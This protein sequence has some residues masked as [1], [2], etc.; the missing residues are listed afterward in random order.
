MSENQPTAPGGADRPA[1]DTTVPAPDAAPDAPGAEAAGPGGTATATGWQPP[2]PPGKASPTVQAP[3]P[4]AGAW[5]PP[6]APGQRPTAPPPGPATP[7]PPGAVPPG[8]PSSPPPSAPPAPAP[9]QPPAWTPP[10]AAAPAAPPAPAAG[11]PPGG[12]SPP[13]PP[14]QAAPAAQAGAPPPAS[15]PPAAGG[16]SPPAPPGQAAA[17]AAPAAAPPAAAPPAPGGWAPPSAPG[18]AAAS[19]APAAPPA[20]GGWAPPSPPGQA[21]GGTAAPPAG[22]GWAPPSAPGQAAAAAAPPTAPPAYEAPPVEPAAEA[23]IAPISKAGV[24]VA[25]TPKAT[26]ERT[27]LYV[28]TGCGIGETV[29]AEQLAAIGDAALKH[30]GSVHGP[31]CIPEGVQ[32]LREGLAAAE[33]SRVVIAACSER[34]NHDVFSPASLG[35]DMVGRVNIRELVAWSKPPGEPETQ[36]LAEDYVRMGIQRLLWSRKPEREERDI[37]TGLLVVG[38]GIS[39]LTAALEAANSGHD[40]HLVERQPELGG[41]MARFPKLFPTTPPYRELE[42]VRID[43]LIAAVIGHPRITVHT[44]AEVAAV[45][46]EPG[47]L[48]VTLDE[49]GRSSEFPAGAVVMATGWQ[50]DLSVL[51]R[52]GVADLPDVVSN[53]A[54]EE[55]VRSGAVVRPSDGAPVRSVAIVTRPRAGLSGTNGSGGEDFSFGTNVLDMASLK[56]ALY[57]TEA[58]AR[59][60]VIYEDMVTPGLYESFYRRVSE[61]P[62]VYFTKGQVK[63][64]EAAAGGQLLV[65]LD[66]SLLGDGVGLPV[67]LVVVATGMVPSTADSDVLHLMYLQGPGLPTAKFGFSDSNFICFPYETR[68]TGIY[69]AGTVREPMDVAFAAEDATGAALKALQSLEL[70]GSGRATH[71]RSGDLSLPATRYQGCTRCGRCSQECPFSA[72]ELDGKGFPALNP[73]RCRRCGICMGACPVQ[74]ISF[75]DYNVDQLSATVKAVDFGDDR[76][77]LRIVAL[78]CENDA[79]PA[80]DLAGIN[81]LGFD[82]AVRVVPLRCLGSLNVAVV[83]DALSSGI[84]GIMLMGCKSGDDYQCHFIQ[85]SA[86]AAKRLVNVKETLDRLTIEPERVLPIE[87]EISEYDRIPEMVGEFVDAVRKLGPNP[88]KF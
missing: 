3:A 9:G 17:S 25:V 36:A 74:V 88:Y 64:I 22:G 13:G 21:G 14:G 62:G 80:F 7:A 52:L 40:V 67:D 34:V 77:Q 11:G 47:G 58:G 42:P 53:V 10:G 68:R 45:A 29:D 87:I 75:E 30:P 8:A 83:A 33:A 6:P 86:L 26:T 48:M 54:F 15:S 63:G 23:W 18:Q 12:W 20:G 82:A 84:D 31:L 16:W 24:P 1:D 66:R 50:P 57:A 43:E 78:A 41:W 69:A 76:E 37:D 27:D 56:H 59:A 79:Y 32:A 51:D 85:G 65:R 71:P 73:E 81:R 19:A 55:M 72:I 5:T 38:G 39:G 44:G 46:G 2:A 60:Y 61:Q 4:A 28:C 70:I 49:G 35:V